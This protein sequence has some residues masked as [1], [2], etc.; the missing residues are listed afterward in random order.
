MNEVDDSHKFI[1]ADC[2]RNG[3]LCDID[4]G[5]SF[6]VKFLGCQPLLAKT[7]DSNLG[8]RTWAYHLI[9]GEVG[10]HSDSCCA[11]FLRYA[12]TCRPSCITRPL[13]EAIL[14]ILTLVK[15]INSLLVLY[16]YVGYQAPSKNG[17]EN[18]KR[19]C[20]IQDCLFSGIGKH[21]KR[22]LSIPTPTMP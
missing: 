21:R 5:C 4:T 3:V 18:L 11:F 1:S 12:H 19:Q 9:P 10:N 16:S 7:R 14:S 13:R 15:L 6:G 8:E 22:N 20:Q 2:R 17:M